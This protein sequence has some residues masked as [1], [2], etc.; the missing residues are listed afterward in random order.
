MDRAAFDAALDAASDHR[1]ALQ[2]RLDRLAGEGK[3]TVYS[4]G[5]RG[6]D[7]AL[8]LRAAGIDCLVFD[9]AAASR[10]RAA[11]RFTSSEAR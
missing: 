7:L 5:V 11:M 8:Q 4:Y 3:L 9:N 1:R 2:P 10:A 6:T